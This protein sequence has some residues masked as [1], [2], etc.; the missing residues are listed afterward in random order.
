MPVKEMSKRDLIQAGEYSSLGS[1][2]RG[3]LDVSTAPDR[4][5]DLCFVR[6]FAHTIDV[7]DYGFLTIEQLIEVLEIQGY[8]V[9]KKE[10]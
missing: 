5:L 4:R 10:Q 8:K 1:G 3:K 6:G 7:E 9:C 2:V